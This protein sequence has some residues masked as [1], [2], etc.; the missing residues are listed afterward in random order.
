MHWSFMY[1]G[2]RAMHY[3]VGNTQLLQLYTSCSLLLNVEIIILHAFL[4]GHWCHYEIIKLWTHIVTLELGWALPIPVCNQIWK[5]SFWNCWICKLL[6]FEVLLLK[7]WNL[8]ECSNANSNHWKRNRNKTLYV[9]INKDGNPSTISI[10]HVEANV[11]AREWKTKTIKTI[12][13]K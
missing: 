13:M 2:S 8:L 7:P 5:V 4:P 3:Y 1:V 12:I 9:Y 10:R 11:I 6:I